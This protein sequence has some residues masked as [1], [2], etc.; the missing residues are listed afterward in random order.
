MVIDTRL[1]DIECTR[2]YTDGEKASRYNPHFSE[3]VVL[4]EFV[5]FKDYKHTFWPSNTYVTQMRSIF[6]SSP[7]L[8]RNK[9]ERG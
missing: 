9:I 3:I 4:I 1:K 5:F 7:K 2:T 8:C 6:S